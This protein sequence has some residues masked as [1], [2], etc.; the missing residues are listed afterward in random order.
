MHLFYSERVVDFGDGL[1]K[2]IDMP[3]TYGGSGEMA[4]DNGRFN[5]R[6]GWCTSD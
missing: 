3:E 4:D 5:G 6:T 2:F 1:P